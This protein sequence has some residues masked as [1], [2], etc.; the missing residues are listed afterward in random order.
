MP[1]NLRKRGIFSPSQ[2][3]S[4]S[5]LPEP[6][7]RTASRAAEIMET[8]VQEVKRRVCRRRDTDQ[9]PTGE[10]PAPAGECRPQVGS[11]GSGGVPAG[12]DSGTKQQFFKMLVSV[13]NN[14]LFL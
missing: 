4:F 1:R 11:S 13:L 10:R 6:T 8:A 3:L 7:S 2:L 5:K 14:S 12:R 9:L